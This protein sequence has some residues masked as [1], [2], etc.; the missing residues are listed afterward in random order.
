MQLKRDDNHLRSPQIQIQ[1]QKKILKI[2]DALFQGKLIVIIRLGDLFVNDTFCTSHRAH[3]S[4][5]GIEK[6]V[7]AAGLIMEKELDILGKVLF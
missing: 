7:K 6:P 3:S 5:V 4:M 1:S 2:S